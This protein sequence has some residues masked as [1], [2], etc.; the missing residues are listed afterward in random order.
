[1][2]THRPDNESKMRLK[3][4]EMRMNST[5]LFMKCLL[6][7]ELRYHIGRAISFPKNEMVRELIETKFRN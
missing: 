3:P 6:R 5:D 2:L 4:V 7:P 1:M